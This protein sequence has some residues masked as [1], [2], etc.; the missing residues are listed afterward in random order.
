MGEYVGPDNRKSSTGN[1]GPRIRRRAILRDR[2][3]DLWLRCGGFQRPFSHFKLFHF[4]HGEV[5]VVC[6]LDRRDMARL[7]VQRPRT[8]HHGRAHD[9]ERTPL[10]ASSSGA[11]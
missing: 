10:S 5:L 9:H 11:C 3:R 4:E 6:N 2:R 7:P 8:D 1:P